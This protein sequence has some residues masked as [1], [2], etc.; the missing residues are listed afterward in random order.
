MGGCLWFE[1]QIGVG[2]QF[3]FSIPFR[4]H[5]AQESVLSTLGVAKRVRLEGEIVGKRFLK[6]LLVDDVAVNRQIAY[7]KLTRMGHIVVSVDGGQKAVDAYAKDVFNLVLMDIQM[8]EID[9]FMATRL[10][11]VIQETEGHRVPVV[12]MTALAMTGDRQKCLDAGLDDYISKPIEQDELE[13]VL[14]KFGPVL[15]EPL[16]TGY[17]DLISRL[18]ERIR[19]EF[20]PAIALGRC[21]GE[22]PLLLQMT[23]LYAAD[24]D[25]YLA[26]LNRAHQSGISIDIFQAI[27]KLKGAF[28]YFC[29][30]ALIQE[31]IAL[32]QLAKKN[33][34]ADY[35][36][37][38][39]TFE[40]DIAFF[41][42]ELR[43][44]IEGS[45]D[46]K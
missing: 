18:P 29:S 22:K 6:I 46:Q 43:A 19:S 5:P 36:C 27:H 4:I 15:M 7:V 39:S 13:R 24:C 16:L 35:T 38:L 21:L 25:G 8:P 30:D 1:S 10:I 44:W 28:S 9:G 34:F 3:H 2:S 32:E 23:T 42:R 31:S 11:R 14:S 45:K 37:R 33:D 26:S 20:D 12:A 41:N 40:L 17:S